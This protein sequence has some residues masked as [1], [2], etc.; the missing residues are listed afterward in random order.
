[1]TLIS[2]IT[3]QGSGRIRI[4]F[5]R[6]R[7][8]L[9]EISAFSRKTSPLDVKDLEEFAEVLPEIGLISVRADAF[10][11]FPLPPTPLRVGEMPAI[12]FLSPVA[13]IHSL[14]STPT[15]TLEGRGDARNFFLSPVASLFVAVCCCRWCA[16]QCFQQENFSG[17]LSRIWGNSEKFHQKSA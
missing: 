11:R 7:P 8:D 14:V 4:I 3:R 9:S 15:D 12:F 6:N 5:T 17:W 10:S 2:L 13:S 16:R 1:M